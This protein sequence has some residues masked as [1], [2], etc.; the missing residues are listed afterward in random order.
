MIP[1]HWHSTLTIPLLP[2]FSLLFL[3]LSTLLNS[4]LCISF[5]SQLF[6]PPFTSLTSGLL[7]Q[8]PRN[9]FF[10]ILIYL[11]YFLYSHMFISSYLPLPLYT[12]SIMLATSSNIFVDRSLL[13][14]C[15]NWY[16]RG[17]NFFPLLLYL[18]ILALTICLHLKFSCVTILTLLCIHV[19]YLYTLH[20]IFICV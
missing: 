18:Q 14:S 9:P 12:Y 15:A 5:F 1:R 3:F 7:H 11:V 19:L 8:H 6:V 16:P 13:I 10:Y 20:S 4:P 2:L 17:K